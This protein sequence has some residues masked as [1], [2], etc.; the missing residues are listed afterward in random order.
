MEN[1]EISSH[2]ALQMHINHLKAT[3]YVQEE[4]LKLTFKEFVYTIDPVSMVKSSLHELAEDKDVKMDLAKV[5]LSF[6]ANFIIDRVLGRNGSI[7][8]FLS[9]MLVRNI[10]SSL[11]NGNASAII[12][13][14]SKMMHKSPDQEKNPE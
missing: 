10:A 9:S 14:I 2:A 5:G 11:I 6:G 3:K 1:I 12:S 13:G 7:K 4:E 8:G